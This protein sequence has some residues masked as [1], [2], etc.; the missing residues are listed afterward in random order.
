MEIRGCTKTRRD[1]ITAGV[2]KSVADR[3]DKK[4]LR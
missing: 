4:E 2:G 1:K 3:A